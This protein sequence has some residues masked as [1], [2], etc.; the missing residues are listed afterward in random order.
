MLNQSAKPPRRQEYQAIV[1]AEWS[2]IYRKLELIAESGA[3]VVLSRLP[4]GDL[5]TQY[6]ADRNIFCAG[7][8]ATDDLKRVV[9]AVGGSIQS[10]VSDLRPEHLGTCDVFE[11]KQIGA[12]RYNL[13]EGCPKAR[14]CTLILRG[15]AEQFISEVERSLN[16]A[17][18]VVRRAVKNG[19]VVAGGGATEVGPS[20]CVLSRGI[21]HLLTPFA[22]YRWKSRPTSER[23]RG[24]C[25]A[26]NSS[27]SRRSRKRS[28]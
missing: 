2:I 6:F 9:S 4:I 22:S 17:V 27:S 13:F 23:T 24:R 16:D 26:S 15:G 20:P 10:T 7:R 28:R 25:R 5:A 12:E 18:Q 19:T 14:T 11:E 3:T 1:D 21:D 8:V